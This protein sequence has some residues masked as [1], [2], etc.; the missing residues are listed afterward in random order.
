MAQ[1][2]LLDRLTEYPAFWLGVYGCG[3]LMT[4]TAIAGTAGGI[5]AGSAAGF[6]LLAGTFGYEAL[7]RRSLDE[8]F[9]RRVATLEDTQHLLQSDIT[10]TQ[11]TL[12]HLR[13]GLA[14]TAESL[15]RDLQKLSHVGDS[16]ARATAPALRTLQRSFETM[17][18]R[19]GVQTGP[20][21]TGLSQTGLRES[22]KKAPIDRFMSR[23]PPANTSMEE[24]QG[25]T[26]TELKAPSRAQKYKDMLLMAASRHHSS[27]DDHRMAP[28]L[29]APALSAPTLSASAPQPDYSDDVV[30]ELIHQA[31]QNDR[32]EI[33]AQPIV[34][35]PS[36]KL[37][38]LELF[39]RIRARSGI[40]LNAENY[41]PLAEK[42]TMIENVD[43]MLLTHVLDTI[44]NDERRNIH[45]GYFINISSRSLRDKSYMTDLLDF[46][47]M[48][49]ELA[50]R[51]VFELQYDDLKNLSPACY[52]LIDGLT[53]IGCQ[54]SV[55]NVPNARFDNTLLSDHGFTFIKFSASHLMR[56]CS[57][58]DGEM[59]VARM[60][61]TLDSSGLVLIVDKLETEHDLKELLDFEID[62]GEG[63]LFGRP[64]LEMAY[65][66]R[67]M[68]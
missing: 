36:R 12:A 41:R 60:K 22:S 2:N 53:H 49:R 31:I 68:A 18:S 8:K 1:R 66:P 14:D 58:P 65:R 57:E 40:Y 59:D 37:Q 16:A 62:Y 51:L 17:G 6:F 39:A 21:Q 20:S 10:T 29:S 4:V 54:F 26:A 61:S 63:Y 56:M 67:R 47:R 33:F 55:D 45:I 44:R 48:R 32:I 27:A 15:N 43:H 24:E 25:A 3:S 46:V 7:T 30:A 28:T 5:A 19:T 34:K 11:D 42:E 52:K 64:D 9:G 38:Y 50:P 35:L 13:E 23:Q